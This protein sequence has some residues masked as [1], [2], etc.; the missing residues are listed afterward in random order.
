MITV[1]NRGP[2]AACLHLLP[3]L[4]FRNTWS[5]GCTHEGCGV[6]PLIRRSGD[7]TLLA[8]HVTLGRFR[9]A[10]GA[11]SNGAGYEWLF[12]DNETNA[13]RLYRRAERSALRQRRLSRLPDRRTTRRPSIRERSARRRRPTIDS[14]FPPGGDVEFRLRLFAEEE[15]PGEVFGDGL[16]SPRGARA[17]RV[18]TSSTPGSFRPRRDRRQR[19]VARQAYAGLLW[20]KQFYHYVVEDWLDGDPNLPPPPESR[21]TG[22]NTD[23]PHLFNRDVISMPDKWEYP[24][25][26]AWDLAFH[27]VPFAR[28]DP[29]FAKQQLVAASCA[30]GTCTPTGRFPA[31]EFDLSDVNPPVHAWACWQVYKMTAPRRRARPAISVQHV[32]RSCCSTSPGGSTAR[33]PRGKHLFSGGFLGLDNI[34][35]FDR[36]RPLP[37]GGLLEQADGT[38]WMAFYCLTMLAMALELAA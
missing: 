30:S 35:V 31:Y 19:R 9:F 18:R 33:T 5:W 21:K 38:A 15:S 25:Y 16:R 8:E 10:A 22:R 28:L 6:K 34:G 32:S 2:E 29:E 27:M 7:H 23:W 20:S 1:V 17:E 24:W 4:W 12:T 3:T 14:E 11:A 37:A 36:S 26:A 13:E